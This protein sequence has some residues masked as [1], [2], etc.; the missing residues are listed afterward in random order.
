MSAPNRARFVLECLADLR[1][2]LRARGG[3]LVVRS[4][5]PEAEAIRLATQTGTQT[6]FVAGGVSRYAV[7]RPPVEA[8]EEVLETHAVRRIA[9]TSAAMN[10]KRNSRTSVKRDATLWTCSLTSAAPVTHPPYWPRQ[11]TGSTR[12]HSASCGRALRAAELAGGTVYRRDISHSCRSPASV[13]VCSGSI[14]PVVLSEPNTGL[15]HP[16]EQTAWTPPSPISSMVMQWSTPIGSSTVTGRK[17]LM[18]VAPWGHWPPGYLLGQLADVVRLCSRNDLTG[19]GQARDLQD[20]P[21]VR[22]AAA[23]KAAWPASA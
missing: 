18:G 3:D 7:R 17:L 15:C 1:A 22:S 6:V 9:V 19:P 21:H 11:L 20:V 23:A 10:S 4:G 8:A 5:R 14:V 12:D 2:G 16:H 13:A